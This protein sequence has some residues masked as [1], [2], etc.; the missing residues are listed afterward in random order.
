VDQPVAQLAA[1]LCTVDPEGRST[2]VS[3]GV[4][5]LTH[6]S[7]H[8]MPEPL[9]PGRVYGIV[10]PMRHVAQRVERGYRLR[11]GIST[12]YFPM[13]WPVPEPVTVTIHTGDSHLDLP[14]RAPAPEDDTLASFEPA[15]TATPLETERLVSGENWVR[16]TEDAATGAHV[17]EV[18]D[19]DGTYRIVGNDITVTEQGYERHSIMADDPLSARA[20]ADWTLGLKRGAWSMR[21]E[22]QTELTSDAERFRIR[23]R[24]RVWLGEEMVAEKEWDERIARHLV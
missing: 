4:F 17:F 20:T 11:L 5:N 14:L 21:S 2:R 24:M 9:E 13:I 12:S 16:I 15:V 19:G 7:G 1:R 3:F 22:T 10:I 23:A 8:E 18:A 6:R